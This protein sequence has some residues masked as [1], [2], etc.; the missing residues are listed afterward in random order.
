[1][2]RNTFE[3]LWS[4]TTLA[5]ILAMLV[6][7]LASAKV[8]TD[9]ADYAPGSEVLISG[10]NS[11]GAGYL[12]GETV[13]VNVQGPNG[14]LATCQGV[15]DLNGAWFCQVTLWDSTLAA[16]LYNYTAIGLSSGVS[17]SGTF[18]DAA[19]RLRFATSG[20]PSGTS[21]T[22]SWTR[23][24]PGCNNTSGTGTTTFSASGPSAQIQACELAGQNT[25]AYAF[26][27]TIVS[28]AVT[29]ALQSS[30]PASGSAFP[31]DATIT[32][33]Y[34]PAVSAT[35]LTVSPASGSY[36]GTTTLSA[37]L[38]KTSDSTFV[39]GKTINFTL[40]SASV[41]SATT[42]GSGVATLS[43]ISLSGINV[44]TYAGYVGASFAGDTSYGASSGTNSLTVSQAT[45]TVTASSHTVT[46]GDA[47]PT[48]T[49][50][51]SGF[52]GLDDAG[53]L[54]TAP[55]CST[56]YVQFDPVGNYP[57]SCAGGV[58]NNYAFSYV[59]GLVTVD[60]ALL[61][62]TASSHTITYGDAAP[63]ITPSYS[64]FVG[65]D[66]AGDLDAAPTCSTTYVQSD[67]VGNYPTSCSGG[68]DNNYAIS[69]VAG[70]VAVDKALLTV[71]ASSDTM[72][73]GDTPPTITPI[74]T[75]LKAGDTAPAT[76]PTCSTTAT[77][78][79]D[80]GTYPSSCSG[81]ADDN[82]TITYASGEVEV[83]PADLLITAS[84]DTMV[85]GDTPPTI[86]PIYT[87]LKAGDTAPATPPT[88][89]T[90]ATNTS[91]VGTYP[92]SCSGAA[93]DNYTITYASG[94]VEVTPAILSVNAVAA[95]KVLGAND[96][97]FNYT[98]S[99]FKNGE[100]ATSAGVTGAASCTRT[101]GETIAGNPYNI[102][103][104]PGTLAATNYTFTTGNTAKF[105]IVYATTGICYGG[106]GHTILQPINPDG[107]SVFK[108]KSTVPAKFRVCD[109]FGN[110]IGTPGV[111]T[112]FKLVK[113]V[114]GLETT[115]LDVI[116][117][118][119][120][121]DLA[122][123]W[124]ASDQQ[125]IFNINTKGLNAGRTYYYDI[126]LNDG[127]HILFHFGLK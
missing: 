51:Y 86:T 55:T 52:V 27:A 85:Y 12:G 63:N 34:T 16:G 18:T 124:S 107:T 111:V 75:G 57:T 62:V 101:A 70:Q 36:G 20:L 97:N 118:S 98:L 23:Y 93:D 46:Y 113:I 67:P 78:T 74:Y 71:T 117:D 13:Q 58:D 21:V 8:W 100:D 110:S 125:W 32:A 121:P 45:L 65:L 72:V 26:P 48:I 106:P 39:S 56:T 90:T 7:P 41:G 76:P 49:P 103:C 4:A 114:Y 33:I 77:N 88:C 127:S 31:A 119:T 1:M 94:E 35:T 10:D 37:T 89:S 66:D 83:T 92:S 64:G 3:K 9:Q 50:S 5:L 19:V 73:Y 112:S 22:V 44:G 80:V 30:S 47:A 105:T 25:F 61:T 95:S 15:A 54:D 122:F 82:Y 69:Y 96:P 28:G 14:Y 29:Y 43:G 126:T 53:D 11:D 38:T 40:N 116:P 59:A 81:A 102:T 99:G 108:L 42:D 79:S 60:K 104:S 109:A 17:Q 91:D 120:T 115:D 24:V 68:V 2:S 123:R 6:A 84:S 87:G